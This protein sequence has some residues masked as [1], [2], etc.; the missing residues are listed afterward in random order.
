[1]LP[2]AKLLL[3]VA[4]AQ[5][6]QVQAQQEQMDLHRFLDLLLQVAEMVEV[7]LQV[8]VETQER[9]KVFQGLYLMFLVAVAVELMQMQA[10]QMAEMVLAAQV[11][12]IT[13]F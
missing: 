11:I 7:L 6:V 9:H 4:A 2:A 1:M 8:M 3:L 10:Q 13:Q 5:E 12:Q